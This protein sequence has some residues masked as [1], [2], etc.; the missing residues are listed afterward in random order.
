MRT[1]ASG[2]PILESIAAMAPHLKE[3][4]LWGGE[5]LLMPEHSDLLKLLRECGNTSVR[6]RYITNLS[7]LRH[8][9]FDVVAAWKDFPNVWIG[10]SLD[11]TGAQGEFMR[12][13]QVWAEAE[14]NAL[15][16]RREVPHAYL[17]VSCTV[18]AM[19]AWNVTDF[20]RDWIERGFIDP[21]D[22]CVNLVQDP[23]DLRPEVLPPAFRL[24]TLRKTRRYIDVYLAGLPRDTAIARQRFGALANRLETHDGSRWIPRF[25]RKMSELDGVRGE[26]WEMVFP[27]LAAAFAAY[28][29]RHS[30]EAAV[31]AL[32]P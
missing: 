15:R 4:Y 20:H 25:L 16:I 14:A 30:A 8:G 13:G 27:E 1:L 5:P 32:S 18:S 11:G 17:F 9:A 19:N 22:F 31:P 6:L 7:H 29:P 21:N 2:T 28:E 3:I 10:A 24:E 12:K 26:S 23:H